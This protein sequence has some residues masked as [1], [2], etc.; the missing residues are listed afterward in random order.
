MAAIDNNVQD[1]QIVGDG[2]ISFSGGQVSAAMESLVPKGAYVRGLNMDFDQFGRLSTRR[3][4]KTTTG[5]TEDRTWESITEHWDALTSYWG[6]TLGSTAIDAA[7]YFDTYAAEHIVVAQGGSL[8]Q[9]TE[10]SV[11]ASI[12]GSSYSG[13]NV[14]FAQ[15]N[16]RLYYCDGVGSLKYID[17][18][19]ANNSITAGKVS[20]ITITEPGSGYTSVPAITFS[21][22]A[23]AATAVLG[24]GGRVISTT[25]GTPSSGYS[26]T[27]PPTISFASA[28]AGGT[29][30]AGRVNLTQVPSKPKFLVAHRNRLFCSSADTGIPPDTIYVSDILDGESWDLV[31]SSIRVGGDGDPI[32][33]IAP[34]FNNS[35]LVFKQRSI[36][37]V[38]ADPLQDV[39]DWTIKIINNRIGC[40]AHRSIQQVGADVLFLAQDGVRALS[41]IE[42]GSQTSVGQ[43]LSYPMQ[44]V[45]DG[46]NRSY[47]STACSAYYRNR[48]FLAIP[49]GSATTPDT[50]IVYNA[51][52][53]SWVGTWTGW[54]PRD[55]CITGFSGRIRLCFADNT[56]K[57]WTWDDYTTTETSSNYQDDTSRYASYVITRA[58]DFGDP[59]VN[60]LMHGVQLITENRMSDSG[61][62]ISFYYD[63]DV[64]GTWTAIDTAL[65]VNA[66]DK[67][68][69]KAYN[70]ISKGRGNVIQF[71]VAT[72]AHKLTIGTIAATAMPDAI[73]PEV[74][75]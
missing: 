39:A 16:N 42:S 44:D 47:Q 8:L 18:G 59:L 50:V 67:Q 10:S 68:K 40:V 29:D 55:F 27:T 35:L 74:S 9:G 60:K 21:S 12:S 69:R 19:L 30:A 62:V 7:F 65:T 22:G 11:W 6:T 45:I 57:F 73:E 63:K 48:Y 58:Y 37:V 36:W 71:K 56:G 64:S 32:T 72:D 15:L 41:Q 2:D 34:W 14:F 38:D 53:K 43:P 31:G 33:G 25:I 24:Y 5:N 54:A 66:G 17:S 3:G 46:I 23:A 1:D 20:S 28:P 70:L 4:A 75:S 26:A 13:P 51:I 52:T 61:V 49:S